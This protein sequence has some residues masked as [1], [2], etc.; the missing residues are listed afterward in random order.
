MYMY[1]YRGVARGGAPGARAPPSDRRAPPY[2]AKIH[3]AHLCFYCEPTLR[4][5][6][7]RQKVEAMHEEVEGI[8]HCACVHGLIYVSGARV[9][10]HLPRPN[11]GYA[12]DVSTCANVVHVIHDHKVCVTPEKKMCNPVQHCFWLVDRHQQ[13]VAHTR[14]MYIVYMCSMPLH[15]R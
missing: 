11:P 10:Q 12:T 7:S 8:V 15:F 1:M 9:V 5:Q 13:G 14:Y 6:S 4:S 3:D 2:S